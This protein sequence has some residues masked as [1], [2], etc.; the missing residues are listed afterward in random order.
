M[1]V[2]FFSIGQKSR[3]PWASI[4]VPDREWKILEGICRREHISMLRL[5]EKMMARHCREI[6]KRRKLELA[7]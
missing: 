5:F 1:K 7:A 2:E 3:K 6:I 4:D